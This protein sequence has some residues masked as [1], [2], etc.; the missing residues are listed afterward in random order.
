MS[1]KFYFQEE[2]IEEHSVRMKETAPSSPAVANSLNTIHWH[3]TLN[4]LNS[5]YLGFSSFDLESHGHMMS[6][7]K[8]CCYIP[9][10][11]ISR[12]KQLFFTQKIIPIG[13]YKTERGKLIGLNWIETEAIC[14]W[15]VS[16]WRA[17]R[18][19]TSSFNVRTFVAAISPSISIL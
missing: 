16:R 6:E 19:P 10:A 1:F 4:K 8:R 3:T 2:N 11:N 13:K 15:T 12:K 7:R 5:L 17:E 14:E 9:D 18:N